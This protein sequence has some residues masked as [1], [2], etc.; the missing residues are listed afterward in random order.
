MDQI[1][2]GVGVILWQDKKVL[3]GKRLSE[4]GRNEWS[5][6][7]GHVE[8]GEAPEQAA[9]REVKEE[10]ALEVAQL[11]KFS[12]TSDVHDNGK[13]YITLFFIAKAWSG[14]M[15]N[16]EPGKCSEWRWFDPKKLPE[17]LF[18]PIIS[19]L[20]EVKLISE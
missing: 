5:F 9:I 15:I 11:S 14:D 13:H 16:L 6:P 19:L 3:L 4:H 10:T 17:P 7:G 2:V 1:K 20:S 18:K 8:F 12:F